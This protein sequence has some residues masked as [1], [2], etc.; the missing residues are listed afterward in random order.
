MTNQQEEENN[1]DV[2]DNFGTLAIDGAGNTSYYSQ[3]ANSWVSRHLAALP[4]N[5]LTF[6]HPTVLPAGSTSP[7]G[8]VVRWLILYPLER[9]GR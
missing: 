8:F 2:I 6:F 3:F 5:A 7:Y 4:I 1:P 9:D